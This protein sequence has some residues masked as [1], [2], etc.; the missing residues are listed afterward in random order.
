MRQSN[1]CGSVRNVEIVNLHL[2]KYRN[3]KNQLDKVSK[4]SKAF[5]IK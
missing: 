2:H 4:F 3:K 5:Y 1:K